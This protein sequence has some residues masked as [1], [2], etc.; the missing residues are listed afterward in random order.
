[1]SLNFDNLSNS[2]KIHIKVK[3]VHAI[4]KRIYTNF[5]YVF[6]TFQKRLFSFIIF[7]IIYIYI[8]IFI[9]CSSCGSQCCIDHLA[10]DTT[11]VSLKLA[12][13]LNKFNLK[14]NK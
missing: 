2:S 12:F 6:K 11:Y 1:M 14:V 8:Y 7:I 3:S 9:K 4:F 5:E 10:S 13:Q